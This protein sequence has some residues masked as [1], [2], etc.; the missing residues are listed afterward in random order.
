ML[1][2][3]KNT[4]QLTDMS[5]IYNNCVNLTGPPVCSNSV[6][7]MSHA[8]CNCTKL[9][10]DPVCGTNVTDMSYAYYG[11]DNLNSD[12]HLLSNNITNMTNCFGGRNT[13]KQLNIYAENNSITLNTCMST[14]ITGSTINWSYDEEYNC[15]YDSSAKI[16]IY[17][18]GG[19][20]ST[21]E[22][23]YTVENAGTV[24][25]F[26]LNSNGYYESTNQG[27]D[28]TASVCKVVIKNPGGLVMKVHV[29]NYGENNYDYGIFS[30]INQTL[31][32]NNVVDSNY[33]KS[34]KGL[35]VQNL[36]QILDYGVVPE[37]CFIY[38]K[39]RKDYSSSVG[40][41]SLQFKIVFVDPTTVE[42]SYT[43]EPVSGA[44][45]GFALN[46]NGYYE[47]QNKGY[48]NSAALCKVTIENSLYQEVIFDCI[49]Y[50]ESTYDFG[51]LSKVGVALST[52]YNEDSSSSVQKSFSGSQSASVQSVSYGPIASGSVIYVKYKK[53]SSMN[54]NNDSLQFKVR[55]V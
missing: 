11:C 28:N 53:D 10:G 5:Y 34:Y 45:Y 54:Q 48:S 33:F 31:S 43:V 9:T 23:S 7:N 15:Y 1:K 18:T 6:T 16:S 17:V 24:Y 12:I 41:D 8:Y 55:F 35:S 25:D 22:S 40:D 13:S 51:I 30:E 46:S 27:L 2:N 26:V 14:P 4:N 20:G 44:S 29:I 36:V 42:P 21:E 38:V 49:N 37:N 19:S 32:L 47:S 39:Y 52:G 50:A 3:F